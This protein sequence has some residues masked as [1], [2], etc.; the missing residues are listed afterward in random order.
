MTGVAHTAPIRL[1]QI[2]ARRRENTS[3]RLQTRGAEDWG[4]EMGA[5]EERERTEEGDWRWGREAE[6]GTEEGVG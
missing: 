4:W 5:E 3:L 6:N 1:G 2:H